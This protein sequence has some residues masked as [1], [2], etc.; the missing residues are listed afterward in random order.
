[1]KRKVFGIVPALLVI[2]LV[3]AATAADLECWMWNTDNFSKES[4]AADITRCVEAGANL[5]DR[6]SKGVTPLHKAAKYN[7]DPAVIK[8]LIDVGAFVHARTTNR[9]TPLHFAAEYNDNPIVIKTLVDA[10]AE[11]RAW[12]EYYWRSLHNAAA[13]NENPDIIKALIDAG[14]DVNV[15]TGFGTEPVNDFET[16]TIAIY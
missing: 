10:G 9:E 8:A 16:L 6:D 3:T 4:T 2:G 14:A 12:N 5:R 7:H 11:V 1:M 15:Q 13:F